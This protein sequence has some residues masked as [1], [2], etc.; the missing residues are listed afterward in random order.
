MILNITKT[1]EAEQQINLF[2]RVDMVDSSSRKASD[3]NRKMDHKYNQKCKKFD[4]NKKK[5][6]AKKRPRGKHPDE[7][8][9]KT[10]M[11]YYNCNKLGYL[12]CEQH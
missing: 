12:S 5:L 8:K 7:K 6:D 4:P 2:D 11:K 9:D 3:F 10:K 1:Q